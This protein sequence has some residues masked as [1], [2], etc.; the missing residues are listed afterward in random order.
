[1]EL[2]KFHET[3]NP[4]LDIL[5][6]G[7]TI[8]HRE[9]LKIVVDKYYSNL[10][11]ELLDE[12]MKNG[13]LL[14]LNRIAWGKSYLKKGGF[15]IY[16][17]RGMVQITQKGKEA[18]QKPLHLPDIENDSNFLQFYAEEKTKTADRNEIR[19]S[20]PQDLIDSGFSAIE[21]QIKNELLEK[22]KNIDPYYFEKVILLLL[23]KMGYGEFIETSKSNDGGI[24]GVINEDKL[25]L[26]KIYIQ[27]KR[28]NENKVREKEIRNFIGAM[29]GDTTKGVFVTTSTFDDS[30]IKK[31][32]DAHHKIILIEGK[33]LVELMYQYGVGVQVK[34]VYEVKEVDEDFFE[35]I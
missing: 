32:Y 27:A 15:I 33:K 11:K 23:E 31:A 26:D 14:I 21:S 20:S 3:F 30:A 19:N 7:K 25:G 9:L 8:H 10:P 34:N 4:I 6:D 16:P 28:Y 2:P 35:A 24:D 18:A 13:E 12:R 1:M 17:E 29:S 5:S 22:L